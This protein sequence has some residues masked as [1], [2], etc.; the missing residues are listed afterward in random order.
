MPDLTYENLLKIERPT[1]TVTIS[2]YEFTLC[3]VSAVDLD[4]MITRHPVRKG[5]EAERNGS[6]WDPAM[7]Y[8]LVS[9]SLTNIEL[10]TEQ[11]KELLDNWSTG[12]SE[13]LVNAVLRLNFRATGAPVPL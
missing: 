4:D 1:A 12:Q 8:E 6:S 3:S 11:V 2:G 13:E 7:R 5:S 9:R 10:S